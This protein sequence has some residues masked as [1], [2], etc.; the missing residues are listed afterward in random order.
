M[1]GREN[2][3]NAL[4][5]AIS[6]ALNGD[7]SYMVSRGGMDL[8]FDSTVAG[9][10]A[11]D[12]VRE[13]VRDNPGLL[14]EIGLAQVGFHN[15]LADAR[16]EETFATEAQPLSDWWWAPVFRLREESRDGTQFEGD[17]V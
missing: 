8:V 2:D 4:Q 5:Q 10:I 3:A 1:A 17:H 14:K 13:A 9:S 6:E 16:G 7:R 11:L 15:E 12:A